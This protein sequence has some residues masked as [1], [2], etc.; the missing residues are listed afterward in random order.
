M[1]IDKHFEKRGVQ[2]QEDNSLPP[3]QRT[4]RNVKRV[5]AAV[6]AAE[7]EFNDELRVANEQCRE[8]Q[9]QVIR[10]Q[11]RCYALEAQVRKSR[12]DQ[13]LQQIDSIT[14]VDK[15]KLLEVA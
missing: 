12:V 9:E 3:G 4:Q 14:V 15:Q 11:D 7:S 10:L 13:Q 5:I 1:S 8:A 2:L 6:R